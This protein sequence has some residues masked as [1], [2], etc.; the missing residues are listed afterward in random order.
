[1]DENKLIVIPNGIDAALFTPS[2][3]GAPTPHNPF[4]VGYLA[5]MT[6]E[7]GHDV[8]LQGF[9]K[10]LHQYF[11]GQPLE[12]WPILM[13][14]GTG[15]LEEDLKNLAKNLGILQFVHFVGFVPEERKLEFYRGLDIFV[16]PTLA[17]GFGLVLIEAM[18]CG[19]PCL[20]S[21]LPVLR[22]VGGDAIAT[23]EAG[24]ASDFAEKLYNLYLRQDIRETLGKKG[25]KRVKENFT[26]ERF[27]E[28]YNNLL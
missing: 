24:Q 22:E 13:L 15:Q 21:D 18:A 16:F 7:K 5:R 9:E 1:M 26:L 11:R 25:Q 23:F 8:L 28:K 17:E 14:G 27:W 20:T 19:L 4:T 12:T 6:V 3:S 2:N 10:F